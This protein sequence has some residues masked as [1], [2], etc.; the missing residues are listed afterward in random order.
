MLNPV[1]FSYQVLGTRRCFCDWATL[2]LGDAGKYKS[3]AHKVRNSGL[4]FPK[5][6]ASPSFSLQVAKSEFHFLQFVAL[7]YSL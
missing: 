4:Y 1:S 5:F 2:N 7:F 6:P 3:I